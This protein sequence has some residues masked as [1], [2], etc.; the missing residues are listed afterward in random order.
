[1]NIKLLQVVLPQ[2]SEGNRPGTLSTHSQQRT[3]GE[4]EEQTKEKE[5]PTLAYIS[6]NPMIVHK[7]A[8][9]GA[10]AVI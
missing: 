7:V 4:T 1:M 9:T 6:N 2:R 10:T 3:Y 8:L 5:Q